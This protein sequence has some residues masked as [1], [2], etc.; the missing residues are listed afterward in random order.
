MSKSENRDFVMARLAA[1]R[2]HMSWGSEQLDMALAL[3]V[4]PAADEQGELRAEI[5]DG[6]DDTIGEAARAIQA[7]QEL[8]GDIDPLEGEPEL[9]EGDGHDE[10]EDDDGSEE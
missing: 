4:D 2:A 1:C 3:F 6:I 8:L 9:P 5:L 7:A 10:D